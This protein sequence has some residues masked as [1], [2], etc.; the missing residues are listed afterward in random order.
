[1]LPIL[2]ILVMLKI[3]MLVILMVMMMRMMMMV[4]WSLYV[5]QANDMPAHRGAVSQPCRRQWG[6]Y[7]WWARGRWRFRKILMNGFCVL[8]SEYLSRKWVSPLA[9]CKLWPGVQITQ[10]FNLGWPKKWGFLNWSSFAM[11]QIRM[12]HMVKL[13]QEKNRVFK[14]K[15]KWVL[16]Y[17]NLRHQMCWSSQQWFFLRSKHSS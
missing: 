13:T 10:E 3:I 11:F 17:S 12:P 4:L 15:S 2:L 9:F 6:Q 8:K 1:M 5:E 14:L 7:W 16:Q